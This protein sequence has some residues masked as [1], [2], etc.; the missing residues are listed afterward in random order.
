MQLFSPRQPNAIKKYSM[1]G[2]LIASGFFMGRV[3]EGHSAALAGVRRSA[4]RKTFLSGSERSETHLKEIAGTLKRIETKMGRI[5][6]A[7][8]K[9]G[10]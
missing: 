1:I 4:P 6:Q 10:K 3:W 8:K 9:A 7:I 5:E 2:L